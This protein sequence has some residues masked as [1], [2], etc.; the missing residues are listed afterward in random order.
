MNLQYKI[1]TIVLLFIFIPTFS[2]NTYAVT[3]KQK[4]KVEQAKQKQKQIQ[5]KIK[6]IQQ[7]KKEVAKKIYIV[8]EKKNEIEEKLE[9][10]E[11]KLKDT[12]YKYTLAQ[13]QVKV[14]TISLDKAKLKYS[15]QLTY[16]QS[17]IRNMYKYKQVDYLNFLLDAKRFEQFYTQ[18]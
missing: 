4:V 17:R 9:T 1:L 11:S 15:R 6:Q 3:K 12:Q 18:G 13:K 8:T 10:T 5:Q 16:A 14:A 7:K 2:L